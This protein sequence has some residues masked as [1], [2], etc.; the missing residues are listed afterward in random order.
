MRERG[1]SRQCEASVSPF[2]LRNNLRDSCAH[3]RVRSSRMLLCDVQYWP[4]TIPQYAHTV[5]CYVVPG[6]DLVY[7]PTSKHAAAP[8]LPLQVLDPTLVPTP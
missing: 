1:V 4:L 2:L 3:T 7:A 8:P 6:T 5:C